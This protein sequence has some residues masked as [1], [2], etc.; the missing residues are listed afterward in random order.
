MKW[1][2]RAE[3]DRRLAVLEQ[4][5]A[6]LRQR[7]TELEGALEASRRIL[8]QAQGEAGREQ[9]LNGLME[10]E[11]EHLRSGLLDIQSNIAGAVSSAKGILTCVDKVTLELRQFTTLLARII[12]ELDGLAGLSSRSGQ[13]VGQ[14][15]ARAGEISSILTL[16]RNIA[17]QTNL[18]ALNAA[19]EAAR[20]G[21]HGRGFAVVADEVRKLADKTRSAIGETNAVIDAMQSDVQAVGES[22]S[23]LSNRVGC[24]GSEVSAF[25]GGLSGMQ[26]SVEDAFR[27]I[28]TMADSVFMSLAKV[29][30]VI[31]KVNTYLSVSKREPMLTFVDHHH[32]RLG[33]WYYEG[34]GK[35]FFS[36]T[37]HYAG[38][39]KPHSMVHQ[40]TKEVFDLLHGQPLDYA[41]LMQALQRM[42]DGSSGVFEQLDHIL[43]D[44]QKH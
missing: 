44:A 13:A 30:H 12:G 34:E 36:Q 9:T 21:E 16:I 26:G 27:D 29:D 22:F 39:E 8:A 35:Q 20:A 23:Q 14:M 37:P 42:E 3:Q 6:D 5:N 17:E 15:S 2:G 41:A 10:Y 4:E 7:L 38:L 31:W 32:C 40:G 1:L 18:L 33:K 43:R 24:V 11:N 25:R 28:S 19:I